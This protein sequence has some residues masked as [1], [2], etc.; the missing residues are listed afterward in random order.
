MREADADVIQYP[1]N[2]V[3]RLHNVVCPYCGGPLNDSCRTKEHVIGR[4][5]V[6]RGKLDAQWNLIVN[7]CR[8]CNGKKSDLEDDISAISMQPDAHGRFGVEDDELAAEARRKA[9]NSASRK[10]R[11]RVKDSGSKLKLSTQ[12]MQGATMDF[13]FS[14]PP[15]VDDARAFELA[16]MQLQAFFFMITYK[17]EAQRGW[18]WPGEFMPFIHT[19]KSDWGNALWKGFMQATKSWDLRVHALA[20]DGFFCC[21]LKRHPS[22]ECWSWAIQWNH[23]HRL[24]GFIGNRGAAQSIVDGIRSDEL[25]HIQLGPA[26]YI[27]FRQDVPLSEAEDILFAIPLEDAIDTGPRES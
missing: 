3:L 26:G 14:G 4:K 19:R 27:R 15:Q 5:F 13:S 25:K 7:A 24:A 16:R 6:P 17:D 12:L 18:W 22:A 9:V 20:A 2:R 23:Q 21:S 1:P 10:T 11:K 8:T